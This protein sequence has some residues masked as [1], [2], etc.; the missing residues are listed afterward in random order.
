MM[1]HLGDTNNAAKYK[2]SVILS[3]ISGNKIFV[4]I[5]IRVNI[6]TSLKFK[7]IWIIYIWWI[8]IT[9]DHLWTESESVSGK[10]WKIYWFEF[11]DAETT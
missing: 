6:E 7:I 5:P 3:I 2:S 10:A 9:G 11:E 4:F 8:E 1:L